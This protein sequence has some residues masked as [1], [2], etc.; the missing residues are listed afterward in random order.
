MGV[1]A[2]LISAISGFIYINLFISLYKRLVI[3]Y[4]LYQD[5]RLILNVVHFI[6]TLHSIGLGSRD[7]VH[8]YYA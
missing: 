1:Y 5:G 4:F 7:H 6:S 8:L 3:L 2:N